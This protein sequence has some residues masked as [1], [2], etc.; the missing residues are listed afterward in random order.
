MEN[1]PKQCWGFDS[2][3]LASG[4]A[5][6]PSDVHTIQFSNGRNTVVLENATDLK[7]WSSNHRTV[8]KLY[9]YVILPDMGSVEEWLG[10]VEIRKRGIQHIGKIRYGSTCINVYD[11]QPMAQSF[12]FRRLA[13]IGDFFG[14]PKKPKPEWL[15]LRKWQTQNEYREFLE[16]AKQDAIITSKF[17]SW[18]VHYIKADPSKY[19]SAGTLVKEFFQLPKRLQGRRIQ[20][21]PLEAMIRKSTFAGRSEGFRTG[22]ISNVF[23][24]DVSSLYPCSIVATQCL[25][26]DGIES[27]KP[28][29][30]S[31]TADLNETSYGWIEGIFQT[32]NDLWGLPLRGK[33]NFYA[34]GKQ[35]YGIY[36]TFDIAASKSKI[37]HIIRA[38]KPTM[39]QR[40][41]YTRKYASYS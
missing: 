22:F 14:I 3:F 39:R 4:R 7:K 1:M 16:Y 9:G 8:R 28:S 5:N 33:N 38:W 35:I 10:R 34:V 32:A 30:L 13:D 17:A 11:T 37:L 12:G 41:F 21:S 24:N 31:T 36:H 18:L 26:I 20:L 19:A 27:C 29:D 15:G 25:R 2:E 23:Y 6:E 40:D